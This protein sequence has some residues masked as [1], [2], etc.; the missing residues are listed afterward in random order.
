MSLWIKK[1]RQDM[2]SYNCTKL[3]PKTPVWV[4]CLP[5]RS[6][7]HHCVSIRSQRGHHP[8]AHA[9]K[10]SLTPLPTA[11]AHTSRQAAMMFSVLLMVHGF[12]EHQ[13]MLWLKT[14]F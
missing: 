13:N 12:G 5:G 2:N 8:T 3:T 4:V 10:A 11:R 14:E 6:T 9:A 1:L 7:H